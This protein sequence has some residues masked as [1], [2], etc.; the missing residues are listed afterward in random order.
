MKKIFI[1]LLG[2][3]FLY[4]IYEFFRPLNKNDIEEVWYEFYNNPGCEADLMN[5]LVNAGSK[6]VPEILSAISDKKMKLRRYAIGA[7]GWIQDSRS[8]E[9]LKLILHDKTE[10]EYF[11]GDA[12]QSLY[13]IDKDYAVEYVKTYSGDSKYMLLIVNAI[14][15]NEVWWTEYP[16]CG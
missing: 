11:R 8:K 1:Y 12:L 3:I 16:K 13:Q 14:R 4:G 7:L 10:I 15:N 5:P 2:L 6:M 9:P